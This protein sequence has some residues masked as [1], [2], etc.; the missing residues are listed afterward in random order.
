[1]TDFLLGQYRLSF[2]RLLGVSPES[3]KIDFFSDSFSNLGKCDLF[4]LLGFAGDHSSLMSPT[5]KVLGSFS[6]SSFFDLAQFL[7]FC[8]VVVDSF[9]FSNISLPLQ[10]TGFRVSII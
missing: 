8:P 5:C 7:S 4:L 3:L 9:D 2:A 6:F 10:L 1:M